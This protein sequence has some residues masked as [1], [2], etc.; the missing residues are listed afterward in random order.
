M[1]ASVV[2]SRAALSCAALLAVAVLL[3]PAALHGQE[4]AGVEE[5][6]R[7]PVQID[8][9]RLTVYSTR[10][11]STRAQAAFNFLTGLPP[12]P[13]IDPS[14]PTGVTLFLVPERAILDSLSGGRVPEWGAGVAVPSRDFILLPTGDGNPQSAAEDRRTLVHEWAH[15]GLHQA[16]P[17]L[18]IPRWFNEGYAQWASGGWNAAEGWKL[19]VAF[20]F[21][22]A[23]P[24]DS[25]SLA[26]PR[27]RAE[28]EL[29]YMLSGT[30]V[31]YITRQ[32]GARGLSLMIDRWRAEGNFDTAFRATYGATGGRFEQAW[33]RYVKRNYGW[34]MMMSHSLAFWLFLTVLLFGMTFMR[35]RSNR[36]KMA[37]LRAGEVNEYDVFGPWDEWGGWMEADASGRSDGPSRIS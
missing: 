1:K 31:E 34:M 5:S 8:S 23:P 22:R 28:A 15:L 20:A 13:A 26:W 35:R 12:L 16:V 32:G 21:G 3:G 27:D 11:D 25:L 7:F 4:T 36:E 2:L 14:L 17:G 9:E 10:A 33:K 18:R 24:L 6:G 30:A 19:R 29:A 37:A